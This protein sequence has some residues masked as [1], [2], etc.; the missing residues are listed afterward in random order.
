M[1]VRSVGAAVDR[2]TGASLLPHSDGRRFQLLRVLWETDD[3][4]KNS[5]TGKRA[6]VPVPELWSAASAGGASPTM[7]P[8]IV[9]D[10]DW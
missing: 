4:S 7:L 3:S 1:A 2:R 6:Q 9:L 5:L 10:C 8:Q